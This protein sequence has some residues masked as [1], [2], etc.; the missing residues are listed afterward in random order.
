MSLIFRVTKKLAKKI[1]IIPAVAQPPHNDPFLD[2]TANL[3]MV[4]RWQC[5]ILTNSASLYSVVI[6]G[7]GVPNEKAFV[8]QSLKALRK[9]MAFEGLASFYDIHIASYNDRITFC[10]AGDRRV[11]GSMNELVFQARCDLL[12]RGYPLAQVNQRLNRIPMSKLKCLYSI[13]ELLALAKQ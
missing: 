10:K 11:L 5:I 9:S 3:F 8:G 4:S 12:E 13:E 2:W 6:P 1:K 7:R